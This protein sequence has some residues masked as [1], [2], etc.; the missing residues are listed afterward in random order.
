MNGL[1][2]AQF[3]AGLR[4]V[5]DFYEQHEEI[6]LPHEPYISNFSVNTKEEA[7]LVAKAL[8]TFDKVYRDDSFQI[9]KEVVPG[10]QMRFYFNRASVCERVVKGTTTIAAHV[11]HVPERVIEDVEW[12]CHPLLAQEDEVTA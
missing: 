9:L 7:V 3:A 1:T 4:A 6:A 11:E 12:R 10:F 2:H 5:A 8:G